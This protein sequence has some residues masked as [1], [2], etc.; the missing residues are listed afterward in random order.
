MGA[1]RGRGTARRARAGR[2]GVSG[3]GAGARRVDL[4][5]DTV[6]RPTPA[7]RRAMAEA[8]VGD[9]VYGEDPTVNRLQALVAEMAGH[10][11][12]LFVPSGTMGNQA[13]I[14]AHVP[15]GHEVI[16]PVGA[17]VYEYEPGAMA[18]VS[19][20]LPRFVRAPGGAPDPADV[21]AA[22]HG[23]GHQAP[24]GLVVIENTH[25]LAGGTVVPLEVVAAVQA[26]AR[27]HGLP[28]HLD[29]A[30]AFNA[31]AALGVGLD[32]VCRG[33]DSASLCLSKG[34]GAP[35]GTVLVGSRELVAEAHRY[36][37]LLG[38][39][40]RQA[41]VLA[42]AGIVA[43]TEGPARLPDDHRRARRLAEGL[44]AMPGVSVDLGSVHTNIVYFEVHVGADRFAARCAEHGVLLNAMGR[45][46]CRL[47]THF[48]VD[49]DDVTW[50]LEALGRVAAELAATA[51]A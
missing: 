35:V 49:D 16:V 38:G 41:G 31:A 26:V 28:V 2:G 3:A 29:G 24:T 22:V 11:A 7:M 47:V 20:A 15:R 42:A 13:A 12:G 30:R 51:T 36:R 34:L 9:D 5:S 14:A 46:R 8:E 48:Q 37:K 25:N 18:V 40:M 6:T 50:A 27:E 19:G 4:R 44:A 21:E 10:E 17:H 39:G 45:R 33:F 1:G 43:V 23:P 32:V